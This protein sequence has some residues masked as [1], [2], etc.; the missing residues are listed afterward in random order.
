[1][2]QKRLCLIFFLLLPSAQAT[3]FDGKGTVSL[4]GSYRN[5]SQTGLGPY[6]DA[7]ESMVLAN[8]QLRF[9]ASESLRLEAT[10]V[11]RGFVSR[12]VGRGPSEPGYASVEGPERFF[13]LEGRISESGTSSWFYD[14]DRLNLVLTYGDFEA[15]VGRKPVGVGT[16]KVLPLWNKFSRPLPHTAGPNLIFGSD[17][18]ILRWQ[19]GIYGLQFM[20]IEGKGG[21]STEAVRWAEAILYHPALELHLMASRWWNEDAVGVALAKDLGGATLRAEGL[22]FGK[23][24]EFQGGLG[25]EYALDETWTLLFEG[26]YQSEG[27]K[28]SEYT[29]VPSRFRALRAKGYLYSQASAQF[30]SF[31]TTN[32]AVLANLV[33]GS[34]YPLFTVTRSLSD[35]TDVSFDLRG[36]LGKKGKEFSRAT[37]HTP[38]FGS[39][40]AASLGAPLQAMVQ[41]TTSF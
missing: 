23:K 11:L 22:V 8:Y 26:L 30:A 15:Q 1:M 18:A 13:N 5:F 10:P 21:A 14:M 20:D 16:L 19:S 29:L 24:R 27:A 37:F 2:L 34:L 4:S 33:D 40:A 28:R 39:Q 6:P 35:S 36:P 9:F 31:W 41:V 25:A 12:M 3:D 7:F 17:A 38:A 32:L